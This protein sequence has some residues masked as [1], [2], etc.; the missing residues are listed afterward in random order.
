MENVLEEPRDML[1]LLPVIRRLA[2]G[3]GLIVA[4]SAVLLLSD[5]QRKTGGS[6]TIK[7][8]AVVSYTSTRVFEDGERGLLD[9]LAEEGFIEGRNLE[10][11]RYNSEGDR[12]TAAMIADE[13]VGRDFDL[14]LTL[15]TPVLQAVANANKTAGQP[16]VFTLS[17]DPWGAGV[18]IS[19]E[20]HLNHPPYMAGHGSL[21]PVEALFRMARQA[22]SD[23]QKVGVVWNPSE[24]N[25]EASTL[26]AREAC[27][28]LGIELIEVTV[29]TSAGV[30]EAAKAGVARGAQAIWVGG[31]STVAVGFDALVAAARAGRVPVFSNMP[32]DVKRGAM[33]G[34]GADYYEVGRKS[35]LL[36]AQV[37][38]GES[39]ANIPVE[40]VVPEQLGVNTTVLAELE[41]PW[42]LPA[43]WI[44]RADVVVDEAGTREKPR[45]RMI[46]PIAGRA[47]QIAVVYFAPDPVSDATL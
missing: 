22:K 3:V 1:P 38:R 24:A 42:K 9:G 31:D 45:T 17:T 13:V 14:I 44:S 18:G 20:N 15:S 43:D 33:L 4:A 28:K 36:A 10:V 29:D 46:K 40:N 34:L 26:L 12:A 19:R 16:H 37:L 30:A 2:L 11:V 8:V 25:S 32:A 39:P 7:R 5:P 6:D 41:Q 27:R 47:Y 23:L 21:Q 35:G